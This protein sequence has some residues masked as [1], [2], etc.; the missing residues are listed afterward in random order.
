MEINVPPL[1]S[2]I[3]SYS[4]FSFVGQTQY[5]ES[6]VSVLKKTNTCFYFL[7]FTELHLYNDWG[8]CTDTQFSGGSVANA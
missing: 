5:L 3:I 7:S 8:K 6:R 4:K 1:S 2:R